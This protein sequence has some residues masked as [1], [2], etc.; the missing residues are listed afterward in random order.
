MRLARAALIWAALVAAICV[1]IALAATSELF[2]WRGPVY[3]SAGFAGI[4]ALAPRASAFTRRNLLNG[5]VEV[6]LQ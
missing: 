4:V 5:E 6:V 1:P 2:E 3:I